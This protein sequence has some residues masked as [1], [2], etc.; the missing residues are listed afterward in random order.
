MSKV[1]DTMVPRGLTELAAQA[2]GGKA[3]LCSDDF[4]ASMQP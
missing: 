4:F 1:D 2:V 3:L